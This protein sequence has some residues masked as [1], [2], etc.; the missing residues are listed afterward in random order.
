V[1]S[2]LEFTLLITYAVLFTFLFILGFIRF[3]RTRLPFFW[4]L[5]GIVMILAGI[6]LWTI[7]SS[8]AV[9]TLL[10]GVGVV[11]MVSGAI[12]RPET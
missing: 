10:L 8:F 4:I 12:S 5:A 6:D 7:L 1:P 2:D 9:T 3:G 11:I